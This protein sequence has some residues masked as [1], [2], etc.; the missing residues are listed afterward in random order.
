[1]YQN[2]VYCFK[3]DEKYLINN[4]SPVILLEMKESLKMHARAQLY[5][6]TI[7]ALVIRVMQR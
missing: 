4:S 3:D 2:M 6:S 1:M 7:M 5:T